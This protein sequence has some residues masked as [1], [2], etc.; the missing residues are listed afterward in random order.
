MSG[1]WSKPSK[2]GKVKMK[3]FDAVLLIGFGG[4]QKPSEVLP[5]LEDVTHGRDIP[6]ERLALV[7]KQYEKI[8]G[9]SPY[10]LL[11]GEQ[12]DALESLLKARGLSLP[13][14]VG[15]A[16]SNPRIAQSL[17]ELSREGKTRVFAI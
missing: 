6:P 14:K 8:G 10:N 4:P 2:A 7:A 13:V 5:F 1:P 16:H 11:T 15:F 17:E 9:V 3:P 12:A